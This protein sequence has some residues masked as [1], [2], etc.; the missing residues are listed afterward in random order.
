VSIQSIDNPG[1]MEITESMVSMDCFKNTP[2]FEVLPHEVA[3]Q[4]FSNLDPSSVVNSRKVSRSFRDK[5]NDPF[6]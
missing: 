3:L 4:I 6:F 1:S 5:T 2:L